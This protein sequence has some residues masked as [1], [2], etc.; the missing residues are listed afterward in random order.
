MR[1][2]RRA[3][4]PRRTLLAIVGNTP[5]GRGCRP[6]C[7]VEARA[8]G[9]LRPGRRV[10]LAD[11]P[12]GGV[13]EAYADADVFLFC[14]RVECSPIVLFEALAAGLPFVSVDV[15]N[16]REIAAWSGGGVVVQSDDDLPG[17]VGALL[18]D[19]E[20]RRELGERGRAAWRQ[21]FTWEAVA[22][23]YEAVY[24]KVRA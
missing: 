11:P 18:A 10:V 17:A 15:G 3:P 6:R 13:L 21:H 14:S 2:L 24:A 5:T 19:S 1:V 9:L 12:R 20:R 8:S 4:G 22:A 7:A 16:A 23:R